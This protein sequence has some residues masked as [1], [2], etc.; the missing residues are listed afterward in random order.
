MAN[1]DKLIYIIEQL[2][3]RPKLIIF[4]QGF[5]EPVILH[6]LIAY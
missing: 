5:Y 4:I 3:T 1:Y 6:K 2:R